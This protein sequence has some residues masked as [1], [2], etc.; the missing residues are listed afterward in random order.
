MAAPERLK[1]Q[2]KAA[3]FHPTLVPTAPRGRRYRNEMAEEAPW[4][5][6]GLSLGH[7]VLAGAHI[8][9]L[10]RN[11]AKVPLFVVKCKRI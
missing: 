2:K 11:S 5:S 6:S 4:I 3:S 8:L 10:S 9:T 7:E 1:N